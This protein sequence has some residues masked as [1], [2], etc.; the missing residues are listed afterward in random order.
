MPGRSERSGRL[1]DRAA[2][3]AASGMTRRDLV[4]LGA[5]AAAAAVLPRAV[6][7]SAAGAVSSTGQCPPVRRG[8]CP[9]G[10]EAVPWRPSARQAIPSGVRAT[11]NGCGAEGGLQL[12]FIGGVDPVPDTPGLVDFFYGCKEHDCCYGVC[13][14][15]KEAC[16]DAFLADSIKACTETYD[17]DTLNPLTIGYRLNCIATAHFYRKGVSG[18]IGQEAF[19]SAQRDACLACEPRRSRCPEGTEECGDACCETGLCVDGECA[20]RCGGA[21][22]KRSQDCCPPRIGASAGEMVCCPPG[23]RCSINIKGEGKCIA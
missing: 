5:G 12:P 4:R 21:P 10:F 16:D 18:S 14:A 23:T 9:P 22:C 1:L 13:G 15:S 11:Y 8:T 2:R 3:A 17:G 19:E 20:R 7:P 6:W